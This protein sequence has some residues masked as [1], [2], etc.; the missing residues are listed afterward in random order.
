VGHV[1]K[2][3]GSGVSPDPSALRAVALG[4]PSPIPSPRAGRGVVLSE[5]DGPASLDLA[6]SGAD[7]FAPPPSSPPPERGGEFVNPV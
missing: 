6:A 4:V 3:N 5:L 2:Q 7:A 1:E